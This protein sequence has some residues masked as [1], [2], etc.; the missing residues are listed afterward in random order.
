[1]QSSLA[2]VGN[3]GG[4][5]QAPHNLA[6]AAALA[7]GQQQKQLGQTSQAT[8]APQQQQQQPQQPPQQQSFV[9]GSTGAPTTAT[10]SQSLAF[11]QQQKQ[12]AAAAVA[13]LQ[14]T[15]WHN[16]Q[17]QQPGMLSGVSAPSQYSNVGGPSSQHSIPGRL[18]TNCLIFQGVFL[19]YCCSLLT[20]T[21]SCFYLL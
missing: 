9:S 16:Q 13:A 6:L 1:M 10:G 7:P 20:L 19:A 5:S 3:T 14:Q 15:Q 17:Q 8:Q 12:M 18:W 2:S 11:T 4:R 21:I